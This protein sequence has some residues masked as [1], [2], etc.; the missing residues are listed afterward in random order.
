MEIIHIGTDIIEIQRIRRAIE[1]YGQ[2]ILDKLFTVN[3]QAY[4][5]KRANPYPSFAA[6]FAGK[7]AVAKALGTGIGSLV[8]W[9]DVE[10]RKISNQPE[11]YLNPLVSIKTGITKV[12]LSISH[13]RE[14]ATAVAIAL[15]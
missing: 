9:K 14:Y 10:I 15:T 4:C 1:I 8:K 2:R 5:L 7:E 3:E 12:I 11:V 13:S 6:R